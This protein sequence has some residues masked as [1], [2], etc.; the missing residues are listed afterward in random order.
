[1]KKK[2]SKVKI[3]DITGKKVSK[4]DMKKIKGGLARRPTMRGADDCGGNCMGS[5]STATGKQI[6]L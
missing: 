6:E 2:S 5:V 3:G 1:M 4:D